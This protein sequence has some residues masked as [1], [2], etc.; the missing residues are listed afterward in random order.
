MSKMES[1]VCEQKASNGVFRGFVF[2][3]IFLWTLIAEI[4]CHSGPIVMIYSTAGQV[5]VPHLMNGLRKN[6]LLTIPK[7]QENYEIRSSCFHVYL[8]FWF[9]C[10]IHS[11][12]S[13]YK[14]LNRFSSWN[15]L[16]KTK[17]KKQENYVF[18]FISSS[19][20]HVLFTPVP[21]QVFE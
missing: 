8:I 7:K 11:H 2:Y 15:M 5:I 16:S 21:L 4:L 19:D 18:M 13:L 9:S 17:T 14:S 6:R 3:L 10:F 20:F 12:L 1:G